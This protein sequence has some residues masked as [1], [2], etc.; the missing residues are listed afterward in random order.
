MINQD[1]LTWK[2][3]PEWMVVKREILMSMYD[4]IDRYTKLPK[5]PDKFKVKVIELYLKMRTKIG[6]GKDKK[7]QELKALDEIS[8]NYLLKNDSFDLEYAIK[9]FFL[10]E[11]LVEKIGITAI[12]KGM[13]SPEKAVLEW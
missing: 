9:C 7:F 2:A 8:Q 3:Y 5:R 13:A 11:E 6:K 12:E 10:L 4:A 1:E